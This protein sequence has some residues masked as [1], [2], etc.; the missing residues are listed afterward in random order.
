MSEHN[1]YNEY[2]EEQNMEYTD[3]LVLEIYSDSSNKMYIVY[4]YY[5]KCYFIKGLNNFQNDFNFRCK[6]IRDIRNF[7]ELIF[8]YQK[9]LFLLIHNYKELPYECNTITF[10][11]LNDTS[12]LNIYNGETLVSKEFQNNGVLYS[13]IEE[14]LRIIK[15]FY[16]KY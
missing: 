5:E 12:N 1:E 11:G 4:D 2:N 9:E 13:Y 10:E 3:C 8:C 14:Q 7:I 6:Y 15:N 16:N